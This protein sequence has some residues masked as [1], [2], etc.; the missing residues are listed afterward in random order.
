MGES[1]MIPWGGHA[2]LWYQPVA[3]PLPASSLRPCRG[4]LSGSA[5]GSHELHSSMVTGSAEVEPVLG[6][7]WLS[8]ALPHT[9]C[10]LW[11][12]ALVAWQS[13]LYC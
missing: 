12:V 6:V 11:S 8:S 2:P 7:A 5:T 4:P 9:Y 3:A 13:H 10:L 1:M